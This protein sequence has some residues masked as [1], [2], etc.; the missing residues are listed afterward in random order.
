MSDVVKSL[1]VMKKRNPIKRAIAHATRMLGRDPADRNV[2]IL[3]AMVRNEWA[4]IYFADGAIVEFSKF[5]SRL[6]INYLGKEKQ[7][8]LRM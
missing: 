4:E 1:E 7:R 6:K 2:V 3:S 5:L 8:D